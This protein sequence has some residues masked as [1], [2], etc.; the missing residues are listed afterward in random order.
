MAK[1]RALAAFAEG[2]RA[3]TED[4]SEGRVWEGA[5]GRAA[6]A[7]AGVQSGL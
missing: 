7:A 3:F 1:P 6:A 4:I 5:A 2:L